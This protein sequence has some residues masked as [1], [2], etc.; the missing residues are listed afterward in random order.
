MSLHAP[1]QRHL[2]LT[3]QP[4]GVSARQ[5]PCPSLSQADSLQRTAQKTQLDA[6]P[7]DNNPSRLPSPA[8]S[9]RGLQSA[10]PAALK[11]YWPAKPSYIDRPIHDTRSIWR[12]RRRI[13]AKRGHRARREIRKQAFFFLFLCSGEVVWL[14]RQARSRPPSTRVS[15]AKCGV[16]ALEGSTVSI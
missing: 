5:A 7:P 1:H 15:Y 12:A 14:S 6:W 16:R 10:A 3:K 13:L 9:L 4:G 8:I 11:A 2:P